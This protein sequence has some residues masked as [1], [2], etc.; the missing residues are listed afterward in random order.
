MSSFLFKFVNKFNNKFLMFNYSSF[1]YKADTFY[2]NHAV[3]HRN[4]IMTFFTFAVAHC[5]RH[6]SMLFGHNGTD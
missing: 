3:F 5:F 6:P 1:I 4:V 2:I